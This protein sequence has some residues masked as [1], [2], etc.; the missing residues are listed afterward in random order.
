MDFAYDTFVRLK[1]KQEKRNEEDYRKHK[2]A[3]AL[4]TEAASRIG[5]DNIRIARLKSLQ[6]EEA[7]LDQAYQRGQKLYPDFNLMF[8][9]R[10]KG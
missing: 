8:L 2:Y 5:I 6:Q 4:R 1:E 3:L 7:Q 10:L 9:C